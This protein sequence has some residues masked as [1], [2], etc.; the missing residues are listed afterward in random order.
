MNGV[1]GSVCG[2]DEK[3][4]IENALIAFKNLV[5]LHRVHVMN[6]NSIMNLVSFDTKIT[7]QVSSYDVLANVLPLG[8]SVKHLIDVTIETESRFTYTTAKSQVLESI[9]EG[10]VL[11]ELGIGSNLH[12][13]LR[14]PVQFP[15]RN[16]LLEGPLK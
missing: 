2:R 7:T 1:V 15:C 5:R 9:L 8:G 13:R 14:S 10:F 12:S 6:V 4:G 11:D 16:A 3:L